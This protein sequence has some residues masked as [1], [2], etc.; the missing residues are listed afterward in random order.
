M[1][2]ICYTWLCQSYKYIL[3][4]CNLDG[5]VFYLTW[6]P[7]IWFGLDLGIDRFDFDHDGIRDQPKWT[8]N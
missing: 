5:G 7:L 6:Q 1:G 2:P 4:S 3:T 8:M